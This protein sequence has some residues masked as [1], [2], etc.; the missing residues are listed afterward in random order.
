MIITIKNIL[1]LALTS[2]FGGG[3]MCLVACNKNN[4]A[5]LKSSTSS[6]IASSLT[7]KVLFVVVDG[8]MGEVVKSVNPPNLLSITNHSIYSWDG[9]QGYAYDTVSNASSWASLLT[10]VTSA[11]NNV[12]KDLS[13]GNYSVYPTLFTRLKMAQSS[14]KT[15]SFSSSDSI[16]TY[17]A[18]DATTAIS[19]AEDDGATNTAA[20]NSIQGT[21]NPDLVFVEFKSVDKAG[22]NGGYTATNASYKSAI[23]QVDTYIGG[24]ISAVQ[25][26]PNYANENW[27]VVVTSN[28]GSNTGLANSSSW[29]AFD[30][31]RFNTFCFYYNPRFV[32]ASSVRPI[33]ILPY[34]GTTQSYAIGG[35]GI[36]ATTGIVS[37]TSLNGLL[38]FGPKSEFTVQCKVKF[39]SGSNIY[40]GFLGKKTVWDDVTPGYLFFNEGTQWQFTVK[41][42]VSSRQQSR[43]GVV[44]DG[45]W[46]TLTGVVRYENGKR[47]LITYTDGVRST[48]VKTLNDNDDFTNPADFQVG[49]ITGNSASFSDGFI[50]DIRVYKIAL[51]DQYIKSNYCSAEVSASDTA[52]KSLLVYWPST[53]IAT[54]VT[55]GN[56]EISYFQDY[57]PYRKP[58][59]LG[60]SNSKSFNDQSTNVCPP[61][62]IA[63]YKSVPNNVDAYSLILSWFKIPISDS[64]NL[65]GQTWLPT[66]TDI[67]SQ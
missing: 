58:L 5:T 33:G 59:I 29:T 55:Q 11:K 47:S 51:S 1:R 52:T 25:A 17:L 26:R 49:N 15:V 20:F 53:Q 66:Y 64:W 2:L 56:K 23:L 18:K 36:Q 31:N 45:L 3:L 40:P 30:D 67:V 4:S 32:P 63:T 44:R 16:K 57:G 7:P 14:L 54:A 35:N 50:T 38:D 65:D 42:S 8:A 43:G 6:T 34:S 61:I 39:S 27:L 46:H 37:N 41:G 13:S 62:S 12:T 21:D 9:L 22:R 19:F 48:D 24:L 60:S 10:G 28:K